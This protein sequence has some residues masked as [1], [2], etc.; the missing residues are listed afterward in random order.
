MSE[1]VVR[2]PDP[3]QLREPR[4]KRLR[5]TVAASGLVVA[6]AACS[7]SSPSSAG[8]PRPNPNPNA[9]ATAPAASTGV[10]MGGGVPCESGQPDMRLGDTIVV[11]YKDLAGNPVDPT[12]LLVFAGIAKNNSTGATIGRPVY[13]TEGDQLEMAS[14]GQVGG[15]WTTMNPVPIE[16][17]TLYTQG[18]VDPRNDACQLPDDFGDRLGDPHARADLNYQVVTLTGAVAIDPTKRYLSFNDGWRYVATL[19]DAYGEGGAVSIA[20]MPIDPSFSNHP[21]PQPS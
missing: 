18:P 19:G 9:M 6:V 21:V 13:V 10:F 4:F 3:Q 14:L 2:A 15:A 11:G 8:E 7:N 17:V 20:G 1:Q 5:T 12:P 16:Q